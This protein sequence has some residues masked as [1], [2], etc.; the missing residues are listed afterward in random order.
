MH[1]LAFYI[2]TVC[3]LIS[4]HKDVQEELPKVP[5]TPVGDVTESYFGK[6]IEDPYRNLEKQSDSIVQQWVRSQSNYADTILTKNKGR[7]RLIAKMKELDTRRGDGVRSVRVAEN[8]SYFY[9]KKKNNE[10]L[11][12]LYFRKNFTDSEERIFSPKDFKPET[13]NNY[14][15]NYIQ[16]SW[17]GQH[18][19]ISMSYDGKELSEIVILNMKTRE[20]SPHIITHAWPSSF[21]GINWLPDNS[22]FTYLHFPVGDPSDENFR[23]NTKSVLYT[24]GQDPTNLNVIFDKES[25][26]NVTIRKGDYPVTK[27]NSSKDKYIIGY[28][29]GVDNYWDAFYLTIDALQNGDLNWK[30]LYSKSDK[31]VRSSGFFNKDEFVFKSAND[32]S[33]FKVSAV[34]LGTLDFQNPK[35][36]IP[37]FDDE[38]IKHISLVDDTYFVSTIKNGVEA[39]LYSTDGNT[40]TPITLP[41]TSG[42]IVLT[43]RGQ[44]YSDLWVYIRGWSNAYERYKYHIDDNRFELQNLNISAKYDEFNDL[45]IKEIEIPSYDGT[46]VPLSIIH[47]KNI[48]LDGTNPVL[49]DGYGAYGDSM[50]PYFSPLILTWILEGGILCTAHVRG[51]GEKGDAWHKGGFKTT[52][53]NTWKDLIACGEYLIQ[54]K[55]TSKDHLAILSSSAGGIMAGRAMTER[56][57][58]FKAAIIQVGMLNPLRHEARKGGGG[59]NYKE[60]GTAKDSIEAMALIE[61]DPYL[62]VKKDIAY[63]ATLLTA[64]ANDTRIPIWIPGKFAARLQAG[65][66]DNLA[67]LRVEYDSGHSGGDEND[68]IYREWADIFS[69]AFWQTGHPDYQIE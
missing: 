45:V 57:D 19:A 8:G 3:I 46:M 35:N 25:S 24:L 1:K 30:P 20:I 18:I 67:L 61:M 44:G 53:S 33:N 28:L 26:P 62:H 14:H 49:M 41:K 6:D 47:A 60:Y 40:I 54:E 5:I 64:G 12:T 36:I 39:K 13:G 50:T 4:C 69:F 51:G 31:V 2:L 68:E 43:P 11:F 21:L 42:D 9:L 22:G 59:S 16:P 55:Y 56:P 48:K 23:K 38:V 10:S 15:I 63:P 29:W 17:N 66:S 34:K 37:P 52:K 58:L 32:A 7:D 27:I 65:N